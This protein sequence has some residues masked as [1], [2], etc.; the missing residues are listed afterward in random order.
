MGL[1]LYNTLTRQKDEFVSL[2]PGQVRMY[3]CGPTVYRFAHIGNLR[4][5]LMSDIL[6]RALQYNGY[7]VK[8]V[9]NITDV[10]HMADEAG[11]D[12]EAGEDKVLATARKE[13]KTP[14]QIADFYT[15]AFLKDIEQI[16]I[17]P[18]DVHPR[19]TEHISHMI[20][21]TQRLLERG[22]AYGRGG[23]IYYDV[24]AFPGYGKLSGNTLDELRAGHRIEL[25]EQ[26]DDLADFLLWRVAG[27]GR[28]AKW[29]SPWGEGFPGWHVECSAMS[30]EYLGEEFDIQ[31]GGIDLIFPHHENCIAQSEGATG[32]PFAHCFVH[33]EHLLAEGRKMAKSAGNYYLLKDLVERGFDPLAFRLLCLQ[34]HYRSKLNFTWD[35]QEGA[36]KALERL[37]RNMAEWR[38][39]AGEAQPRTADGELFARRFAET[40]SD[41][42]AMP[43][44]LVVVWDVVA[45]D[46][47]PGEKYRLLADFDRVLGLD[48]TREAE[49]PQELSPEERE[50]LEK[51]DAARKAKDWATA[52]KLR[53]ELLERGV[54]VT[55]S[56]QG[57][58]W[59]RR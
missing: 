59:R 57:T 26:K 20:G 15:E 19:A 44:T 49:R 55:D 13:R 52:D 29:N 7:Q 24:S 45:S 18:A 51:R 4:T 30:I 11:L 43:S 54:E 48:L 56:P 27:P 8:Q 25:D 42:L 6:K 58:T 35:A 39:A 38:A 46:L 21:I 3:T 53:A 10:G 47:H 23:A 16:N 34:S 31:A 37:R 2:E 1:K 32:K 36:Q 5:Y 14:R 41:D 12:I 50:L 28:I 33:A 40:I 17:L 22:L 9:M